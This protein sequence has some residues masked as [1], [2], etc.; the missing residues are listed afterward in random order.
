MQRAGAHPAAAQGLIVVSTA[1]APPPVILSVTPF[2]GIAI[3]VPPA[4]VISTLDAPAPLGVH[5]N[6]RVTGY[7]CALIVMTAEPPC[8]GGSGS[9]LM[10]GGSSGNASSLDRR[11]VAARGFGGSTPSATLRIFT[12]DQPV[13]GGVHDLTARRGAV[14]CAGG[15]GQETM[16]FACLLL[17]AA[18]SSGPVQIQT[19]PV[20]PNEIALGRVSATASGF[21]LLSLI[22]LGQNSRF[23]RAHAKA[24]EQLGADRIASMQVR[25]SWFYCGVGNLYVFTIEG[26]GVRRTAV[27]GGVPGGGK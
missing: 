14:A 27:Q 1:S 13:L 6:A 22:P 4:D 16:R 18:C 17:L 23:E 15:W 12:R 20:G 24:C 25:E 11:I 10:T 3:C 19:D 7:V 9:M 2:A 8:A 21:M 26:V 5:V